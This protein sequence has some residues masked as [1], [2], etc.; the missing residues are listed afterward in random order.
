MNEPISVTVEDI[1]S[2]LECLIHE[3]RQGSYS[4]IVITTNVSVEERPIGHLITESRQ[5]GKAIH[6]VLVRSDNGN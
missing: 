2:D 3:L 5:K 1:I 4:Q 6:L